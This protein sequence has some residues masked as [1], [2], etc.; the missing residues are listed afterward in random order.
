MRLY[1]LTRVPA[2]AAAPCWWRCSGGGSGSRGAALGHVGTFG[3]T[4][5]ERSSAWVWDF[6]VG[7]EHDG[8]FG[9][10]KVETHHVAG[11]PPCPARRYP[12]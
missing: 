7:A 6:L 10:V 3:R 5:A 8:T 9:Q 12:E 11:L 2:F 1:A 4:G